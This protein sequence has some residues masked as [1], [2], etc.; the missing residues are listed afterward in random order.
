M[1]LKSL[2]LRGFKSF[3]E[4]TVL[5]FEQGITAIVGPNGSGKSNICDAVIWVLGEQSAR[6]LR[7]GSMEDVIFAG[8]SARPALGMAEVSL[9]LSNTDGILP[10]E[11]SE[12][13]ITRRLFRSGESDY[14]INNSPCRLLDIQELLSDTGLGKGLYSIIG[15]GRLEEILSSKPEDK[16]LLIEEAAGILKHKKR[17]ERALKKLDSMEQHLQRAKDISQ[18]INRQ[19]K[20]LRNQANKAQE[21]IALSNKLRSLEIGI[22]VMDLKELQNEWEDVVEH[23]GKLREHLAAQ[24]DELSKKHADYE[25]LQLE[26][27]TKNFF[28]GDISDKRRK[29]Q[30][31]EEKLISSI[32]LLDEKNKNIEQRIGEIRHNIQQAKQRKNNLIDQQRWLEREKGNLIAEVD[33]NVKASV[34]LERKISEVHQKR[35]DI[36]KKISDLRSKV[37]AESKVSEDYQIKIGELQLLVQTAENKLSFLKNELGELAKR[38]VDLQHRIESKKQNFELIGIELARIEFQISELTIVLEQL[39]KELSEKKNNENELRQEYAAVKARIKALEDVID[40]LPTTDDITSSSRVIEEPDVIG[41]IKDAIEVRPEYERAIEAVLGGDIFCLVLN[42]SSSFKDLVKEINNMQLGLTS[43]IA[44]DRAK[45]RLP[46]KNLSMATWA[47]DVITYPEEFKYAVSALLSHVYI[48]S[49]F[50]TALTLSEKTDN[51]IIAT[52]DGEIIL[53]NGKVILGAASEA[54]GILGYQRELKDLV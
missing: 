10:I 44:N 36:E 3:A 7:S 47:L 22:A 13:T 39:A 45:F 41:L 17:K 40:S 29:L 19:L 11:F 53:P 33:K 1:Q 35:Q 48:V 21:Y 20:P 49:D 15:Q 52:V 12:V 24:K 16:R 54:V 8:S 34:E 18:E 4:R 26:F 42:S 30:S 2:T 32:S 9:C 38:K 51:E 31:I 14:Y 46:N 25:K 27:E 50:S 37:Q 28:S 43:L 5:R 6:S 23:E